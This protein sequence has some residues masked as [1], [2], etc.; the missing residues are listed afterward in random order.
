MS[1]LNMWHLN[2]VLSITHPIGRKSND[3][4]ITNRYAIHLNHPTANCLHNLICFGH[5]GP[6]ITVEHRTRR[7]LYGADWRW[8]EEANAHCSSHALLCLH[9]YRTSQIIL[10]FEKT[11]M[12]QMVK[13]K[14]MDLG[15]WVRNLNLICRWIWE[16]RVIFLCLIPKKGRQVVDAVC[17]RIGLRFM[18]R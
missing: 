14:F 5:V 1:A 3:W 2:T 18:K 11:T 17:E 6:L 8:P 15:H 4:P 16:G 10:G 9:N 12:R 7:R 13:N